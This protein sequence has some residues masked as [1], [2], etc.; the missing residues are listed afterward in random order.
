MARSPDSCSLRLGTNKRYTVA[1]P[2]TDAIIKPKYNIIKTE[3]DIIA[4]KTYSNSFSLEGVFTQIH[5][6]RDKQTSLHFCVQSKLYPFMGERRLFGFKLLV[7]SS[8][9]S[10]KH[11]ISL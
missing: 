4:V 5:S 8:F 10:F 9:S 2:T 3:K 1:V 7:W 6:K 11:T